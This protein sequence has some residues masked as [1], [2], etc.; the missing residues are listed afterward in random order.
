MRL[1]VVDCV[2]TVEED[3]PVSENQKG[4]LVVE[5]DDPRPSRD[6]DLGDQALLIGAELLLLCFS[7]E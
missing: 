6:S 1:A 4:P 7:F 2:L 3:E 5:L